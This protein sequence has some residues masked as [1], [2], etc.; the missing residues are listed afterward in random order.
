MDVARIDTPRYFLREIGASDVEAFWPAFSDP[1]NMRY[2]SRAEFTDR[3]E[4][5]DYLLGT[6]WGGRSWSA[7]DRSTGAPVCRLAVM[8]PR[9]GTCE[10]G[11]CTAL[12]R[13]GQGVAR[14]CVAALITHLFTVDGM[15]RVWADIDPDNTASNALAKTLGFTCEGRLRATWDTHIGIRDSLIWGLLA[16]EWLARER[17]LGEL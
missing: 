10:I 3:Q 4:L 16:D 2:W 8:D 13:Q 9:N 14:E 11:Y 1:D 17:E 6:D 12:D 7:I 5:A 15:R